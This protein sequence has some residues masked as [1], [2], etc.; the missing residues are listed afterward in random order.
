MALSE[1]QPNNSGSGSLIDFDQAQAFTTGSNSAGY[2]LTSVEIEMG[3][4][5]HEYATT[6]TVCIH[7][8]SS[9]APGASLGTLS[10]PASLVAGS[11][12]AF[13]TRGIALAASTTCFVVID[14]VGAN[15]GPL[16]SINNTASDAEDARKA[17]GWSI[18]ND[19]LERAWTSSGS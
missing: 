6:F 2:T 18:G 3:V 5:T 8:N 11:V 10:N 13:T 12:H 15:A 1:G 4:D 7:S 19:S 9:G 17:S 16:L 14:R